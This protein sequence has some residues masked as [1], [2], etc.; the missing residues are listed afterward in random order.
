MAVEIADGA[1]GFG[2]DLEFAGGGW[3]GA[4]SDLSA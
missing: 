1:G 2:E 4:N 3:H